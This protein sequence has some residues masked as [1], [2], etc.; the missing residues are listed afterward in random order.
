MPTVCGNVGERL[1]ACGIEQPLGVQS[2]FERLEPFLERPDPAPL[3]ETDDELILAARFVDGQVAVHLHLH[4]VRQRHGGR[5]GGGVAEKYARNLTPVVLE[6]EVLVPRRLLAVV[7]DF[8][9]HPRPRRCLP[10]GKRAR[11]G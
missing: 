10:P 1:L 2:A 7:G 4:S 8:A 5:R 6:R 11:R 3:H 9:F